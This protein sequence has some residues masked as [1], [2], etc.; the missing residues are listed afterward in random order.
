M[1]LEALKWASEKLRTQRTETQNQ[2]NSPMLE[3]EMLLAHVLKVQKSWLFSHFNDPVRPHEIDQFHHL[4]K[5]RLAHEP[6]A[7]IVGEKDFYKRS[8]LVNP[9][10]LIPRPSTETLIEEAIWL[11]Q[12]SHPDRTLLADIGTGSGAIAITLACETTLSVIASDIDE[13]TLSLAKENAQKH[14]VADRI[15]F[16][17]GPYLEPLIALFDSLEKSGGHHIEHLAI[18]ANLPYLREDQLACAQ[19]DVKLYEP[20]HALLAGTDG[21]DAY[22]Q[23]FHSFKHTQSLFPAAVSFIIEIDPGQAKAMQAFLYHLFPD[24]MQEI[25]KDL[26]GHERIIVIQM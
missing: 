5:R 13:R 15:D 21:M 17:S 14:A 18:C 2:Y 3:A 4:L 11:C 9:F 25:K 19:A 16:R 20:L 24:A 26:E 8:F 7:Y 22:W 12:K 1:I 10:V 23:L 6:M